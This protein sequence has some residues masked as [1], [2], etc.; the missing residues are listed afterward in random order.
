MSKRP[1]PLSN[2]LKRLKQELHDAGCTERRAD[3]EREAER[4]AGATPAT[5]AWFYN[6]DVGKK[7]ITSARLRGF[8][9]LHK[10]L[11]ENQESTLILWEFSKIN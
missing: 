5:A 1:R 10:I 9:D 4:P 3:A 2:T 6:P 11:N 7:R 8:G